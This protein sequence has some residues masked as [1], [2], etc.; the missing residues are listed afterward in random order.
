ME[1][2]SLF[3]GVRNAGTCEVPRDVARVAAGRLPSHLAGLYV[4]VTANAF[5]L[6]APK[7][8]GKGSYQRMLA[9]SGRQAAKRYRRGER[10]ASLL[11]SLADLANEAARRPR[12][13]VDS[14]DDRL[15]G[16]PVRQVWGKI[17]QPHALG[18]YHK[19]V[20]LC[21]T[22]RD[23][24]FWLVDHDWEGC[25]G[26]PCVNLPVLRRMCA[27]VVS[28]SL[29]PLTLYCQQDAHAS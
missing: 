14:Q 8:L 23:P 5:Q 11:E 24:V 28:D 16:T 26:L 1:Q 2:P 13:L 9:G 22:M 18:Q 7:V 25:G 29:A 6:W 4:T 3:F 20:G 15:G 21:E 27:Q 10:D 17:C 12:A 19:Q